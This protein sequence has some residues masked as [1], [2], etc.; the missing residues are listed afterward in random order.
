MAIAL[1]VRPS[2]EEETTIR[3]DASSAFDHHYPA[4]V[5]IVSVQDR[6]FILVGTAH[7]SQESI[8]LV[9]E[10]LSREKP[11]CVCVELDA[12]RYAALSQQQHWQDLDLR[13]V[14]RQRHLGTLI[15]NLVLASYQKK[16]GGQLGVLPGTELLA[17][18]RVAQEQGIPFVLC[19]REVRVTLQR[20]WRSAPFLKKMLLLSSLVASLFDTTPVSEETL[21]AMRRQDAL[22]ALLDDL[23]E[24]LP[25]LRTVLIDERDRYMAQKIREAAG[26]RVVAVVGAAHVQGLRRLLLAPQQQ[27]DLAPLTVV[28]PASPWW[29]WLGWTIPSTIVA[30]LLLIGWQQG[31]AAAGQNV[32]YWVLASG[33]PSALG[34]L[35]ALAHPVTILTAFLAAPVTTL[36]PVLGV[37]H[38]TALVQ[39]YM[40]PPMV[41]EFQSV[42]D[43]IRSCKQWW[44]NRLLRVFLAFLFPSLGTV[45]GVWVGG[46][47]IV[48]S[49]F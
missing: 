2:T 35:C 49:L 5:Q 3:P 19:D 16:L 11:D 22:S 31:L 29:Q 47:K 9:R 37:G 6:A 8:A 12:Q 13:A 18:T 48:S 44:K 41:R 33:L 17:A 30:A 14:I 32:V 40:Q 15:V 26:K 28:P 45:L 38:I 1:L 7:V 43:D 25:T 46:Y 10:V 23:G 27:E 36:S 21:R 24:A 39:A 4:D 34:A 42:A 20:A